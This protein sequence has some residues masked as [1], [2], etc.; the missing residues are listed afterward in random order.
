MQPH[1]SCRV[2]QKNLGV[3]TWKL[4]GLSLKLVLI[5]MLFNM[6]SLRLCAYILFFASH[7]LI[8]YLSNSNSNTPSFFIH[9]ISSLLL[10]GI[11]SL[12]TFNYSFCPSSPPSLPPLYTSPLRLLSSLLSIYIFQPPFCRSFIPPSSSHSSL[13]FLNW[14]LL[15]LLSLRHISTINPFVSFDSTSAGSLN[16][17][18]SSF[19]PLFADPFHVAAA[20]VQLMVNVQINPEFS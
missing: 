6:H 16:P 5:V 4:D 1:S 13:F 18:F 2:S 8:C 20:V 9:F 19:I 10:F 11:R 14:S 3:I 7:N 15:V 12:H 17:S